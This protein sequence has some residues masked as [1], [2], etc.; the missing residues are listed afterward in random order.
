VSPELRAVFAREKYLPVGVDMTLLSPMERVN[1]FVGFLDLNPSIEQIADFLSKSIDSQ[2]E[3]CGIIIHELDS[4]GVVHAKYAVGF[5]INLDLSQTMSISD[6]NPACRALLT[7]KTLIVDITPTGLNFKDMPQLVR[8]IDYQTGIAIPLTNNLL[9]TIALE[10]SLVDVKSHSEYFEVIR[11]M[12]VSYIVRM[13]FETKRKSHMRHHQSKQLTSRQTS[14][15]DLVK[16][17][18]TN[19]SIAAILGYSESLIRQETII[20]YRKLG[21]EGRRD[22]LNKSN[23]EEH[24]E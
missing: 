22:L 3:I 19:N 6:D 21:V 18:R 14:I 5:K 11:S 16:E 15:L 24:S 9:L 23:I 1:E 2:G 17:G 12:L 7:G 13:N 4:F 8:L 20:I 10:P